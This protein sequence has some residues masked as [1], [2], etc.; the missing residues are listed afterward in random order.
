MHR[1]N[2]LRTLL[3]LSC[4]WLAGVYA[5]ELPPEALIP[6]GKQLD[7]SAVLRGEFEQ[8]KT[9]KGFKKPLVSR[10][11]FVIARG[12]GVQWATTQP[13]ASTLVITADRLV[14][15]NE[16]GGGQKMDTRQEP[17]LR[18]FNETLMAVLMGDI[19]VL[20]ARFKVEGSVQDTRWHLI[21]TPRDAS[22]AALIARI[23]IEGDTQV[24][25]IQLHEGA[26]DT[27]RLRFFNH[28]ADVLSS[29]ETG[30]FSP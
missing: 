1:L 23:D 3:A 22:L 20:A 26:G 16:G 12:K 17:G 21:L 28:K 8:T 18:A 29:A 9:I 14:T 10:G 11:G 7:N 19:K 4:F 30:R 5:A 25:A 13:F 6:I 24:R 2:F 15:I 27:S